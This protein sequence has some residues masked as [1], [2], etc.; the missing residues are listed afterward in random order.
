MV[1][2]CTLSCC[3]CNSKLFFNAVVIASS[4][5]IL[6]VVGDCAFP[7]IKRK[8]TKTKMLAVEI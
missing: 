8:Q 2:D 7:K 4:T 1:E 5:P 6:F 3:D